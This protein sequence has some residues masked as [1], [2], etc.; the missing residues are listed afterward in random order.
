MVALL[1]LGYTLNSSQHPASAPEKH[2]SRAKA[3]AR[4]E[5]NGEQAVE[6]LRQAAPADADFARYQMVADRNVFEPPKPP[7][8]KQTPMPPPL[9]SRPPR[10][11]GVVL[12]VHDQTGAIMGAQVAPPP[13]PRPT[14]TGW[15]YAGYLKVDDKSYG[16]MQNDSSNTVSKAEVGTDFQGFHVESVTGKEIVLSAGGSRMTLK[17]PE[18]FSVAP[19]GRS[20][21]GQSGRRGGRGGPGD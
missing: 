3:T 2:K 7:Q 4:Q 10:P 18:D 14:L 17:T 12:P 1:V 6:Q 19:L 8:P 13:P 20:A 5:P 9:P 11:A 21:T 15:S 16:I